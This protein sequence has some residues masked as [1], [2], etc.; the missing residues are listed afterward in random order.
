MTE[1]ILH[2]KKSGIQTLVQDLGRSGFQ[3]FGVPVNGAMDRS[4][5]KVANW[6]VG[7]PLDSPVL[8]IT[9]M[10]PQITIAGN[11]QIALTGAD[12]SPK[13]N[14][15][16]VSR[17]E[18]I[19]ITGSA[20][21]S[22]GK[23]Q[24]GCRAYLAVGGKWNVK[25]WLDSYSA[26][27]YGGQELTPDSRIQKN[28]KLI[29]ESRSPIEKRN[30]PVEKRPV[31][32]Q[33]LRIRVLPGPE[34]E[35]FSP[36][37]IGYFFSRGYRLTADSNRMGYRLNANIIDFSPDREVISSG[38]IPGTIQVTNSGQP[39]IL[40]ADAQT[41]GGYYRLANVI[42]ADMDRLA[43]LKPGDE[44]WFSLVNLEEAY[45]FLK[46]ERERTDYLV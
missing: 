13:L 36:Y 30:Y 21:L 44:V 43:Q 20:E 35:A 17:Y 27:T 28:S 32:S 4:A 19:N 45:Q 42:S 38:I 22:F 5:A 15:Q 46:R 12:L 25:K 9:L 31:F 39:I 37:A 7:N 41:T 10:G 29:I 40:M 24:E 6:L 23:M 3:A 34:F 16:A 11:C 8:E 33:N 14:Q 2:F 1:A 26:S 18:T